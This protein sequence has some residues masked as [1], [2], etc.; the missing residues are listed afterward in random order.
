M[1]RRAERADETVLS[2][3]KAEQLPSAAAS[4]TGDNFSSS[5]QVVDGNGKR[6]RRG[7]RR[8]VLFS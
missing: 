4:L 7:P 6:A 1:L 8:H 5:P 2:R 3:K